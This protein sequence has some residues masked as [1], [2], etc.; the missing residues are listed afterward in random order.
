MNDKTIAIFLNDLFLRK[1]FEEF[2]GNYRDKFDLRIVIEKN[3]LADH[4]VIITD[5]TT[6]LQINDHLDKAQKVLCIGEITNS[7]EIKSMNYD[8]S[9]LRLPFRF[10][11]LK[12]RAE[13]LFLSIYT[14]QTN[15]KKFS[16]FSYNNK[17]RTIERHKVNLRITEKEN[18]IFNYLIDRRHKYITRKSLLS[19]IWNYN[20]DIDTHTLETHMYSLRKKIETKLE[21]KDLIIY[22]EK[23]GYKINDNLL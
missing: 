19:E 8:I 16:Q 21:L 11:E 4:R 9:Y 22:K 14:D 6:L 18:E 12:E 23:K 17:N 1:I 13:N 15:T 20:S 10:S 2:A 7:L 5:K 3:D